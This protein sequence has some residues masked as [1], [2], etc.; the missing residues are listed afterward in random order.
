M[1][2]GCGTCAFAHADNG[3]PEDALLRQRSADSGWTLGQDEEAESEPS[4]ATCHWRCRCK[5]AAPAET[6]LALD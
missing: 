1:A 4:A 2:E 6:L 3:A 5:A